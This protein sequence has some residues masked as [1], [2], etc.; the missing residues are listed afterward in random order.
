M[1]KGGVEE[2]EDW[3]GEVSTPRRA[4]AFVG[5][6]PQGEANEKDAK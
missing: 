4:K 2:R 3:A 5:H 6:V 1:P